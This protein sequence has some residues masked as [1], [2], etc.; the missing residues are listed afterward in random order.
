MGQVISLR[1]KNL[2][3]IA[4]SWEKIHS[5]FYWGLE[6]QD[7]FGVK[8]MLLNF[9]KDA[10]RMRKLYNISLFDI[11]ELGLRKKNWI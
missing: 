6:N 3:Q 9:R 1:E 5:I 11:Q 10:T 8:K 4:D 2:N 7:K